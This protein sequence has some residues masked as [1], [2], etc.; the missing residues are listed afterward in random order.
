MGLFWVKNWAAF[1]CEIPFT[2]IDRSKS[3]EI[4]EIAKAPGLDTLLRHEST[5]NHILSYLQKRTKT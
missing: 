5:M 1:S 4:E 2:I 3:S